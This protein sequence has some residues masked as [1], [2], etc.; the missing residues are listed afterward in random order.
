MAGAIALRELALIA[1]LCFSAVASLAACASILLTVRTAR[2]ARQPV[3]RI[4]ALVSP[5]NGFYG[6]A[7]TNIGDGTATGVGFIVADRKTF[8]EGHVLNGFL[9]P[10]ETVEVFSSCPPAQS[11]DQFSVVGVATGRDRF[12]FSHEWTTGEKEY[13]NYR[14]GLKTGF[15]RHPIYGPPQDRFSRRFPDWTSRY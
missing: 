3:L 4:Q 5:V 13:V 14:R 6:V 2:L 1:G 8:I 9:R 7:I 11:D 15:R 12:S 10:G